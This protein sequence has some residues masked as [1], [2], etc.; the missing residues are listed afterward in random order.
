MSP[1]LHVAFFRNL[2]FG[3][4]GSPTRGQLEGA[5]A[6]AGATVVRSVQTNGTVVLSA[7][8][9]SETLSACSA[10]LARTVGYA[11]PAFLRPA[12][13]VAAVLNAFPAHDQITD[14]YRS[15]LTVHDAAVPLPLE[16]PW[17][18]PRGDLIV[19]NSAADHTCSVSVRVG[20]T[21]GDPN[22]LSERL[23]GVPATTRT[24]NTIRRVVQAA[25]RLGTG[26][27]RSF[28]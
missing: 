25:E 16:L 27:A 8:D 1:D 10:E 3:H 13:W 6:A 20:T 11:E 2:N 15:H 24:T 4:R 28:D 5:L 12:S 9:P 26:P 23:L 21:I 17:R 18:S 19:L 14:V 22:S 7:A